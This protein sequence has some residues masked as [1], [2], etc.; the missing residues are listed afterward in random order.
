MAFHKGSCF[1]RLCT[2][3]PGVADQADFKP[4]DCQTYRR[5][6]WD[7][8][9]QDWHLNTFMQK[10]VLPIWHRAS[11]DGNELDIAMSSSRLIRVWIQR[12]SK[13]LLDFSKEQF[14]VCGK[15]AIPQEAATP[16]FRKVGNNSKP[17]VRLARGFLQ[18]MC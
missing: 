5:V 14:E 10:R 7:N 8:G 17:S 16:H 13:P 1:L 6:F 2:H 3:E 18:E 12:F 15:T 4:T 9:N 11:D